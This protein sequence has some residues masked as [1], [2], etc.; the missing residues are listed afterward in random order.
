MDI[1]KHLDLISILISI[2]GRFSISISRYYPAQNHKSSNCK[3]HKPY[4]CKNHKP[5][6]C[7]KH[8]NHRKI[9]SIRHLS[10]SRSLNT[11][12]SLLKPRFMAQGLPCRI[13][14]EW[15]SAHREGSLCYNW[16]TWQ[17]ID[18]NR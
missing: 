8:I 18:G 16:G 7:K 5:S 13:S 6:N 9:I 11:Y 2:L 10:N 1:D 14:I 15:L 4:N 12:I 17:C 3:N